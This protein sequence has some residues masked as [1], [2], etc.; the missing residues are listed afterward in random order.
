MACEKIKLPDGSAAIVCGGR[1]RSRRPAATK[2]AAA[3][4]Q[5]PATNTRLEAFGWRFQYSRPCRRCGARIEFWLTPARKWAPLERSKD[6][7]YNERISHFSTCP[8]AEEFRK[9]SKQLE[10]F[11]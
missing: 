2:R 5:F 6:S 10:M 4:I 9:K 1:A 7:A 11:G 3:E 8:F